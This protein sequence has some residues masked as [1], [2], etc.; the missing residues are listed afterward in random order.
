MI[1]VERV[2]CLLTC[3]ML[4]ICTPSVHANMHSGACGN[5]TRTRVAT[6][7]IAHVGWWAALGVAVTANEL[8]HFA[9]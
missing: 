6:L 1:N 4:A 3:T 7:C 9:V 2:K 8:H 5:T